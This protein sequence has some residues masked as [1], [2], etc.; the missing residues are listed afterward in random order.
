M[1]KK[2]DTLFVLMVGENVNYVN[3]GFAAPYIPADIIEKQQQQ[4]E[5]RCKRLILPYCRKAKQ[6]GVRV[7]PWNSALA[8]WLQGG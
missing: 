8:Y 5:A 3:Y 1:D 2:S 6:I 7:L 4:E